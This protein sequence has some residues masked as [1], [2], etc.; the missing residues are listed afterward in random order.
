MLPDAECG[1]DLLARDPLG[2]K[3]PRPAQRLEDQRGTRVSPLAFAELVTPS[4]ACLYSLSGRGPFVA[5]NCAAL[6][7][8]LLES[9]LFGHEKGAFTGAGREQAGLF[10]AAH[11]GTLFLDEVGELPRSL[12]PKLLRALEEGEV[13]GA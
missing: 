2:P 6:P 8:A 1:R 9:E 3:A 12:Q 13:R 7:E 4:G 5:I 10:E 11:R